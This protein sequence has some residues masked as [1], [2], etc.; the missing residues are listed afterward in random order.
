MK[1]LITNTTLLNTGDSAIVEAMIAILRR[2]FGPET[3]IICYGA[4]AGTVA[5][6]RPGSIVRPT[7]FDQVTEWAGHRAGRRMALLCFLAAAFL[8]RAGVRPD[9]LPLPALLRQ[10]LAEYRSADIVVSAGGTY[11][12]P[13][14]RLM[15]KIYDFLVTLAV[16]RPLILFTQSLGPFPT[17][18]DRILLRAT[19]RHARL[20]MVRDRRSQTHLVDLG[21]SP[22]RIAVC[23]DAAF[24][25]AMPGIDA[26]RERRSNPPQIAVSV[27]DWPFFDNESAAEGMARY[28]DAIAGFVHRVITTENARV[29]FVSSCQGVPEYW[30]DDSSVALG[31]LDRLPAW[32]H[33]NVVI[34]RVFRSP[35]ELIERLRSFDAVVATRMHIAI[36]SLCAGVPVIP[37]SYEFKTRELAIWLGLDDLLQEIDRVSVD[38]LIAAWRHLRNGVFRQKL[39]CQVAIAHN[40]ALASGNLVRQALGART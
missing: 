2:T 17:G 37:I 15:P 12:V 29:T 34:D 22:S 11:L 23:A 40:S 5:R 36:L 4:Q 8:V 39:W 35:G 24:A 33:E 28:L 3:S 32:M 19:L 38:S 6:Y 1:V 25:L 27:R 9:R 13:N 26:N 14:Y 20:V 18:R 30:T 31:V 21:V 16:G 7:V 10:S